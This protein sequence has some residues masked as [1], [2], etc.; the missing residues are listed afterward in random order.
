VHF[1]HNSRKE[2]NRIQGQHGFAHV[3]CRIHATE[4]GLRIARLRI[5]N[6]EEYSGTVHTSD[7]YEEFL[8]L[9]N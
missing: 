4:S 3:A 6:F 8:R 1:A 7:A 2:I 5:L 9:A